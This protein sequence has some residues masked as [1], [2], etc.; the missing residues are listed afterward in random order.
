LSAL[1]A[2]LPAAGS[3]SRLGASLPKQFLE[4]EG[5]SLVEWSVEA[6]LDALPL[7][8]VMLAL[9]P[10]ALDAFRRVGRLE[11]ARVAITGGGR[12]R[13]ESVALAL[14]ALP[15]EASDWVLVHDAAR[16]CVPVDDIRRLAARVAERGVGGIL[17]CPVADTL[18]R[19]DG[20]RVLETVDRGDL[21]RALTP[22][23]FAVG[24]L[25]AALDAA[26]GAGVEP[27]DEAA[28]MERAGEP[29]Q[30]VEGS[31]ANIKVTYPDDLALA[32]FWLARQREGAEVA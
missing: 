6:L 18:K 31:V 1:W 12:S 20:A 3:G 10:S 7:A 24:A 27:T 14:A 13:A 21:W 19:G 25:R 30:L 16:P 22:Q 23:M 5:R 8:G 4:V 2:V 9:P 15:A 11:D 32:A 28:A 17:A 29:V 26:L